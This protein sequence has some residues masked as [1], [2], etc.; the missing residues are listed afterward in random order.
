MPQNINWDRVGRVK[1]R[2]TIKHEIIR[3][4]RA[5]Q[6][7][8]Q[9]LIDRVLTL[10]DKASGLNI[11]ISRTEDDIK[12]MSRRDLYSFCTQMQG[13]INQKTFSI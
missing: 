12:K 2:T 11:I 9:D 4:L 6:A 1:G 13:M 8:P 7:P 10:M 3:D 5:G